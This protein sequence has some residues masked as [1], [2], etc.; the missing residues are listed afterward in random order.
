MSDTMKPAI[1]LAQLAG[2]SAPQ[3]VRR[4]L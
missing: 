2:F 4:F 3:L 1:L